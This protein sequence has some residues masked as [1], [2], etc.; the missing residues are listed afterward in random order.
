MRKLSLSHRILLGLTFSAGIALGAMSFAT[1]PVADEQQG[2]QP[3]SVHG[4]T[5]QEILSRLDRHYHNRRLDDQL[6]E[7]LL[8][9]YLRD[10]D[11]NH[12]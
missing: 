3:E 11:P 7:Q 1:S 12:L 10:L 5:A 4:R 6:S 8:N 9:S 2:L